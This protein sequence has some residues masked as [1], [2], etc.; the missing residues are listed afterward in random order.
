M[1]NEYRDWT[2]ENYKEEIERL[3]AR[4]KWLEEDNALLHKLIKA[5]EED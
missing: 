3:R 5:Y 2:I 1:S 4:V